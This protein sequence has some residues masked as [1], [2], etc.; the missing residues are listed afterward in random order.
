[1]AGFWKLSGFK[2]AL[3]YEKAISLEHYYY[4]Y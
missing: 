1:M 3:F 4:Y 2:K